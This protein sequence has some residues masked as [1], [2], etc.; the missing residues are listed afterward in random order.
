MNT[1]MCGFGDCNED[2]NLPIILTDKSSDPEDRPRFCSYAHAIG[3]LLG[4]VELRP[5]VKES[6]MLAIQGIVRITATGWQGE[7]RVRQ[8][9][10]NAEPSE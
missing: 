1:Y 8:Y 5:S 9:P 10:R 6:A 2:K 3:W 7:P 4:K